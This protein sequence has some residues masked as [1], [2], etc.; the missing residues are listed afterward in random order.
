MR[1]L[2]VGFW[3]VKTI[4]VCL[5]GLLHRR[6]LRGYLKTSGSA[7]SLVAYVVPCVRFSDVVRSLMSEICVPAWQA[8]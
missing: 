1:F 5:D 4:A 6:E 2:C 7:V 3:A 8:R